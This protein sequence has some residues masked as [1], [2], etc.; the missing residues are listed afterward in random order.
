MASLV[1]GAIGAGIGYAVGPLTFLGMSS[2]SIG[3]SIGS[4]LGSLLESKN[5]KLPTQYGPRLGDL[6]VQA[7]TYGQPMPRIYGSFRAAGNMIWSAPIKETQHKNKVSSG[8]KGGGKKKATQITYTYSQSFALAICEGPIVGI[9]RIWANGELIYNVG[10][11]ASAATLAASN[12]TA[13]GITIY[14]GSETQVANSLIQAAVGA[15]NCPAYRGTAYVVFHDLQLEKFG[16]R[17]PN[18]EFEVIQAD[19]PVQ[20]RV[21]ASASGAS[22]AVVSNIGMQNGLAIFTN[23]TQAKSG[24][25]T[26][27]TYSKYQVSHAGVETLLNS[28]P[29]LSRAIPPEQPIFWTA[30]KGLPTAYLVM[31][32]Y[33]GSNCAFLIDGEWEGSIPAEQLGTA[34]GIPTIAVYAYGYVYARWASANNWSRMALGGE[35]AVLVGTKGYS[36]LFT[37]TAGYLYGGL[38]VEIWRLD[39]NFNEV[40]GPW[41]ITS[42]VTLAAMGRDGN[43][44]YFYDTY[45]TG[46]F[47]SHRIPDGGTYSIDRANRIEFWWGAGYSNFIYGGD[48]LVLNRTGVGT[49]WQW[50]THLPSYAGT[51]PTIRSIVEAECAK[52]GLSGAKIDAS[53]LTDTVTGYAITNRN[54]VRAGLEPL[55]SAF[56]FDGIEVDGTLKFVKRGGSLAATIPEDDLAAHE[57]GS[58]QPDTALME[59]TQD[60]ELPDEI[61]LNYYDAAADYMIGAQYARRLIGSSRVQQLVSVAMALSATQAKKVADVLMFNAWQGRIGFTFSASRKYSHLVPS[62]VVAIV[63]GGVSYTVRIVTRDEQGGV[64]NFGAVLEDLQIYDQNAPAPSLPE[65]S[66]EVAMEGPT[67]LHM[68]DIPLLRDMDNGYGIYSAAH[69]YIAGWDGAQIF[70][71]ADAS[72]WATYGNVHLFGATAGFAASVLGDFTQNIFDETNSV[73]VTLASGTLSSV[74]EAGVLNGDNAALLGNEIIQFKTATLVSGTTWNLTGLLRGRKGTEWARSAHALGERFLLLEAETVIPQPLAVGD[75]G[76][77]RYY[78]GVT[79]GGNVEDAENVPF[80]FAGI[81][82]KPYAPVL[83][84]GGRNAAGDLTINWVRRSRIGGEWTNYA[85]VPLGEDSEAYEV[86]IWDSGYATLKRTITGLTSAT[87]SY[88]TAE[89]TTDFGSAQS[90]V[91]CRV[92]QLSASV[93]RGYKLEGTV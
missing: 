72:S 68:L 58:E 9:R 34:Y 80:T 53:A 69:G 90:T 73:T 81:S 40:E 35:G 76:L 83:L 18:V 26:T 28:F 67:Q 22:G 25:T 12:S 1:L 75:L 57:W 59:R 51:A 77:D 52:V 63:K 27:Y 64:I 60:V 33:S 36:H 29:V 23:I 2:V 4:T 47:R 11:G 65:P 48:G 91:Y 43:D 41:T 79:F 17:T 31:M 37:D 66:G 30:I 49:S 13:S 20:A 74:T 32:G 89:Q 85:E 87:A 16:N 50:V 44:W 61:T 39:V 88:T 78:R 8:G 21:A 7:S 14:T 46:N 93:G 82:L 71:S 5:A 84:G 10:T 45:Y 92:Y 19:T 54:A 42:S 24:S 6:K 86:E 3:W 56:S 70:K 62:D 15:A 38:G 55:S